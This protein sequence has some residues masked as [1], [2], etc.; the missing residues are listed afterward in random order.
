M[1]MVEL[2][3]ELLGYKMVYLMG[4]KL[5]EQKEHYLAAMKERMWAEQMES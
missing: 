3:A 5:V 2:L 4:M 1:I